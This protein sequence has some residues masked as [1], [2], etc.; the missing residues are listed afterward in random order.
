MAS[1]GSRAAR[2]AASSSTR[3]RRSA[4][5]PEPVRQ[6]DRGLGS[7]HRRRIHRQ[8]APV[9]PGLRAALRDRE[10]RARRGPQRPPHDE[11]RRLRALRR[12]HRPGGGGAFRAARGRLAPAL[13]DRRG[14]STPSTACPSRPGRSPAVRPP[15]SASSTAPSSV[16]SG[17]P[18]LGRRLM[19]DP[20]SLAV[21]ACLAAVA[22]A[23]LTLEDI[24][25]L[26]T[27]PG[28]GGVG[29]SEGG[30]T[31]VEEALRL[32]PTWINGGGDLPGPGGSI[33]AAAMAVAAGPLP[34]RAVLPHGLGVD[35]RHACRAGQVA[36]QCEAAA[37]ACPARCR[38]GGRP[39][40]RCPPPTGSP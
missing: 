26:S 18:A 34:P 14:R 6:A 21:D 12:R 1:S 33:I 15:T 13:R 40:A 20:L 31:A 9:A 2:T 29:M 23:G 11:H 27:Y 39:S 5:L 22:D 24:D 30:A 37:S 8:R 16:A 35:V 4:R 36:A 25:G 38:S 19:V 32:H 10:R 7:R 3:P 17:A 28:P